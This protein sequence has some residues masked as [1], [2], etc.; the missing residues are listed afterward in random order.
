MN[1]AEQLRA[2]HHDVLYVMAGIATECSILQGPRGTFRNGEVVARSQFQRF[3]RSA[4]NPSR[5]GWRWVALNAVG[6]V[7]HVIEF[8]DVLE[9]C[10]DT[11]EGALWNL[12]ACAAD[13][14]HSVR[15]HRGH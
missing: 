10:H 12:R 4:S 9:G 14:F 5:T 2:A 1:R 8:P 3:N 13:H 6:K 11:P 15:S 7:L